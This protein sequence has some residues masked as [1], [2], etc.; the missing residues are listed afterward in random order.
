MS[1]MRHWIT[2]V[3]GEQIILINR[4]KF[5][6]AGLQPDV[7]KQT[8]VPVLWVLYKVAFFP[9]VICLLTM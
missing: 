2:S 4:D 3:K 6:R 1:F 8:H 7:S 5:S 9:V